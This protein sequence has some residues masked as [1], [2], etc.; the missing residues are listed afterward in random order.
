M[1]KL[2]EFKMGKITAAIDKAFDAKGKNYSSDMIDLLGLRVTADFQ[3]KITTN[4]QVSVEDI[5]DSV[6]NV[7]IQADTLMLPRHISFIASSVKRSA[8]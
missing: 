2:D 8:I 1:V 7:L 5:Q 4:S 3:N 6:E